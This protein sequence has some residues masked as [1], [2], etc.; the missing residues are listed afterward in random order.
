MVVLWLL[1]R[2]RTDT[3]RS[4]SLGRL[5]LRV[6]QWEVCQ[7]QGNN[8]AKEEGGWGVAFL[9][10]GVR[11]QAVDAK[12]TTRKSSTPMGSRDGWLHCRSDLL[13]L[14]GYLGEG[15]HQLGALDQAM[16]AA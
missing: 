10:F 11:R 7:G 1:I 9:E 16:G 8:Q 2:Q 6:E 12:F 4:A 14:A 5:L 3:M 13:T 15:L